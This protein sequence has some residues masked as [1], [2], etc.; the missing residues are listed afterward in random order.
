MFT[1]SYSNQ[2]SQ[3][4]IVSRST[5]TRYYLRNLPIINYF[6]PDYEDDEKVFSEDSDD[7]DITEI[8]YDYNNDDMQGP[9][10]DFGYDYIEYG[11]GAYDGCGSYHG[12]DG[13]DN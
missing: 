4:T 12:Y 5:K 3:V 1:R 6:E 10:D 7:L 13:Y 2:A 9:Y 8:N 11:C